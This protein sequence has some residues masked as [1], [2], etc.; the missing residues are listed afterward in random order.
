MI[1]VTCSTDLRDMQAITM[2]IQVRVVQ[3]NVC[4]DNNFCEL[5]GTTGGYH[6][7]NLV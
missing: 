7:Y 1:S 2:Y 4:C 6:L 5:M 3:V